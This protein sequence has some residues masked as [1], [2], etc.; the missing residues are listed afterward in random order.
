MKK[1]GTEIM[2]KKKIKRVCFEDKIQKIKSDLWKSFLNEW[3]EKFEDARG[4]LKYL[5]SY[6]ENMKEFGIIKIPVGTALEEEHKN[7]LYLLTQLEHESEINFYKP[8]WVNLDCREYDMFIDLSD[9]CYPIFRV[10]F[11]SASNTWCKLIYFPRVS[12]LLEVVHDN[13]LMK[14]YV[15]WLEPMIIKIDDSD[16]EELL[17]SIKPDM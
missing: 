6:S 8:Y 4:I 7:W 5:E 3:G 11:N 14:K 2:I 16:T 17:K 12:C 10:S 9:P 1:Q 13:E 15:S